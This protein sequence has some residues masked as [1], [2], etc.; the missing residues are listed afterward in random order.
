M[1]GGS[2]IYDL[3]GHADAA[4]ITE[5]DSA[6]P[7]IEEAAPEPEAESEPVEAIDEDVGSAGP[8]RWLVVLAVVAVLAWLGGMLWLAVPGLQAGLAPVALVE[9]IAALCVVPALIGI[10][11]LLALRTST[12][13][14]R[15]FGRTAAA[16]RAEAASLERTI[17][18]LSTHLD[19]NR[20]KLADQTTTLMAMGDTAAE[21][22]AAVRESMADEVARAD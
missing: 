20:E 8:A 4:D 12:A 6:A 21:R 5:D 1:T 19:D 11:W 7:P 3:H 9:F 10:V 14:A 17:A 13:E 16:M 18:V 22:L 15:R 2:R